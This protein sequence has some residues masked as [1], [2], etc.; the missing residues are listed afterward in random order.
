MP[1]FLRLLVALLGIVA[2]AMAS[3]VADGDENGL[4]Q[5]APRATSTRTTT[6]TKPTTTTK[7]N[8]V[9]PVVSALCAQRSRLFPASALTSASSF[10]TTW[11]KVSRATV[12]VTATATATAQTVTLATIVTVS[13]VSTSTVVSNPPLAAFTVVQVSGSALEMVF[14]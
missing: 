13:D 14:L 5:M 9:N 11:L 3:P 6:S 1:Q 7:A 2:V 4:H 8:A 10:C 12:T